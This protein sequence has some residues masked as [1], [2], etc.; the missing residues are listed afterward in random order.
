[1]KQTAYLFGLK[2]IALFLLTPHLSCAQQ[3][4]KE[5]SP[6]FVAADF[7][8]A[9]EQYDQLLNNNNFPRTLDKAGRVVGT[10]EWD[11][12]GGFFPGALWYVYEY[13]KDP[14]VK[15]QATAWTEKLEKAKDLTQH[16]DI[17][18]VMYCSYGN[19]LRLENDSTKVKKY[20]QLLVHSAESALKRFDPKV[21][22]IKSW[23][24]K[25]SWDGNIR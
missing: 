14:R 16:H 23:N 20:Q 1:M 2:M 3:R 8:R 21:G 17:G 10:D 4:M 19:A 5:N 11:W 24:E 9:Q 15:A 12:T 13:T 6:E 22:L 25:A 18:F 7:A